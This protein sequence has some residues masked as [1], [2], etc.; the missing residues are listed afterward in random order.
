MVGE[1]E[2]VVELGM[3][4]WAAEGVEDKE[5][6]EDCGSRSVS[7]ELRI[8]RRLAGEIGVRNLSS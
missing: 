4:D 6:D 7:D 8:E 5:Q 1:G 2:V 3:V